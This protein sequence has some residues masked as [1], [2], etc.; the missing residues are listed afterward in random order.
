M[1]NTPM[2][3]VFLPDLHIK[4]NSCVETMELLAIDKPRKCKF[5]DDVNSLMDI[6]F[7]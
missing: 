7:G 4:P 1:L 5:F 3:T 6:I 2:K